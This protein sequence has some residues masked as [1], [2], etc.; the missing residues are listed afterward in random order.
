[1]YLFNI[2]LEAISKKKKKKTGVFPLKWPK[3]MHKMQLIV[4]SDL[5]LQGMD[6]V[7]KTG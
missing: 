7:Q 6:A 4:Q 5:F 1:M 3:V 2:Q